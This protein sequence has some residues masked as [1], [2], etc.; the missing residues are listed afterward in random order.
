[1]VKKGVN[2][3]PPGTYDCRLFA[4]AFATAIAMGRRPEDFQFDQNKMR[5]HLWHCFE[6]RRMEMFP[7]IRERRS[8]KIKMKRKVDVYCVCRM[9]EMGESMVECSSCGG[10]YHISCVNVPQTVLDTSSMPWYCRD[11]SVVLYYP[12]IMPRAEKCTYY[13]IL[14]TNPC[15]ISLCCVLVQIDFFNVTH[16]H[17]ASGHR[18]AY[19]TKR[20]RDICAYNKINMSDRDRSKGW[21]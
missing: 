1:M 11:C 9:P 7:Y 14:P 5:R 20:I 2:S 21:S 8:K 4:I 13:D 3:P 18:L 6:K 10:W 12:S 17:N 15:T 19:V 16:I